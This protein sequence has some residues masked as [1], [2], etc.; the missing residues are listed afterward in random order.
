M[1]KLKTYREFINE[2]KT[3]ESLGCEMLVVNLQQMVLSL[4]EMAKAT[5]GD[6][7][8]AGL[9]KIMGILEKT[10]KLCAKAEKGAESKVEKHEAEETPEHEAA[11]SAEFEAGEQEEAGEMTGEVEEEPLAKL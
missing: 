5:H 7:C 8:D 6:C 3:F 9:D 4:K 11:E 2:G 10:K 1:A